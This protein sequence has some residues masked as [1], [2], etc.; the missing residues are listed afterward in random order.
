MYIPFVS[1]VVG[2]DK[3]AENWNYKEFLTSE[4]FL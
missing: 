4:T 3:K 2:C 1:A